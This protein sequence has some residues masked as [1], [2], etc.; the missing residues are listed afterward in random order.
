MTAAL[1]WLVPVAVALPAAL[2]TV[3]RRRAR[4]LVLPLADASSLAGAA[5][6]TALVRAGIAACLVVLLVLAAGLARRPADPIA[7]LLA[8]RSSTVVVLDM[9]A[10]VSDPV[11]Q[12]I[13]RTLQGLV[14]TAGDDRRIGLVLFS[15]VAEEALPPGTRATELRPFIRYF[16]PQPEPGV[17]R[18]PPRYTAAGPGAPPSDPYP[19]SPWFRKFSGGTRISTGLAAARRAL[20]RDVGGRGNVLLLSDLAEA[21]E[22]LPALA[23]ELSTYARTPALALTVVTLPPATPSEAALFL[24]ILG[25]RRPV[26]ESTALTGRLGAHGSPAGG[27]PALLVVL[28]ALVG[29]ALA[30]NE[31]LVQPLAWK[32]PARGA[33]T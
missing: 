23:R 33:A 7:G 20:E 32:R 4:P 21:D 11:Y 2:V 3:L 8:G 5:R 29:V 25:P 12:E 15:D 27:F 1:P 30:A 6:R 22:D 14:R 28:T 9:S 24:E 19:L 17:R 16:L 13:A 10:S 18:K 26:V 31:L